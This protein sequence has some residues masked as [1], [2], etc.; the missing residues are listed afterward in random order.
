MPTATVILLV[1]EFK[2]L[3]DSCTIKKPVIVKHAKHRLFY[4]SADAADHTLVAKG[5]NG[6][7]LN[8]EFIIPGYELDATPVSFKG[9]NTAKNFGKTQPVEDSSVAIT[10]LFNDVGLGT[11]RPKWKYSIM[12]RDPQTGQ[13]GVIDPPIENEQ[14][15]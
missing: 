11:G 13:T 12:I 8:I 9:T 5:K 14:M 7:S 3:P 2:Q 15:D 1:D 4:G 10:N 6:S